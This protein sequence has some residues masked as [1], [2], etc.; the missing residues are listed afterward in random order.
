[1]FGLLEGTL[2]GVVFIF[3]TIRIVI[4]SCAGITIFAMAGLGEAP[5]TPVPRL[6][7]RGIIFRCLITIAFFGGVHHIYII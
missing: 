4:I 7:L 1:M 3:G 6:L 5:M 2:I